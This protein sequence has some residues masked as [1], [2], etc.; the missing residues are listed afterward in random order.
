M[1]RF[2]ESGQV[3]YVITRVED[4]D[5]SES[6]KALADLCKAYNVL[7][8]EDRIGV[9]K[10][11]ENTVFEYPWEIEDTADRFINFLCTS[12]GYIGLDNQQRADLD[13]KISLIFDQSGGRIAR[14]FN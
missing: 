1:N 14:K 10:R 13:K 5:E 2:K 12:N 4:W 9:E 7:I 3:Q 6:S 11:I 8:M